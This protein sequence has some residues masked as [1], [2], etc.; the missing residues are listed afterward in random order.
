[1]PNLL[2][3]LL[4]EGFTSHE[5][6]EITF[7]E[8]ITVITGPEGAGKSSV[9][10]GIEWGLTGASRSTDAGGHGYESLIGPTGAMKVGLEFST[11]HGSHGPLQVLRSA[12]PKGTD[13]AVAGWKGGIKILEG[14]MLER[15]GTNGGVTKDQIHALMSSVRF[16]S[17]S[18]NDQK[19][20]L[21]DSLGLDFDLAGLIE[22][23]R[24]HPK[25][26]EFVLTLQ[27]F[28]GGLDD[29][30]GVRLLTALEKAAREERT[31]ANREVDTLTKQLEDK[32]KVDL[33]EGVTVKDKAMAESQLR[34]LRTERDKLLREQTQAS[35]QVAN[36]QRLEKEIATLGKRHDTTKAELTRLG[37]VK[38]A[39]KQDVSA[40][41]EVDSEVRDLTSQ[42]RGYEKQFADL[43]ARCEVNEGAL[44]RF[45]ESPGQCV[46]LPTLKCA[47]SKEG[48]AHLTGLRTTISTQQAE[49][50][51]LEAKI[52]EITGTIESLAERRAKLTK[53]VKA[54]GPTQ[55]EIDLLNA[56]LTTL[57]SEID[58]KSAALSAIIKSQSAASKGLAE[59][60]PALDERIEKGEALIALIVRAEATQE[61]QDEK[62][63][64]LAEA[65]ERAETL[66]ALVAELG[67][68]GV[69]SRLVQERLGGF[70]ETANR[71]AQTITG[72]EYELSLIHEPDLAVLVTRAGSD[73]R[74][75]VSLS[76]SEQIRMGAAIQVA[77]A[78]RIGFPL[79]VIDRV[80]TL[81]TDEAKGNFGA[82]MIEIAAKG[83]QV[84]AIGTGKVPDET[85]EG[86]QY[87][88]VGA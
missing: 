76:D 81:V 86:V 38:E 21:V 37:P 80:E 29:Q 20:L 3:R 78:E 16:F 60:I 52:E 28:A 88:E 73:G 1:M 6:T 72:G 69:V 70:V 35:A 31:G 32:A 26:S 4:L 27:D 23:M 84:I 82:A 40:V 43:N 54:E 49:L 42:R 10:H 68:K 41:G 15:L 56:N 18:T 74:L 9:G 46:V 22:L 33:P 39:P 14:K 34:G 62:T 53:P 63:Q 57:G 5:H 17:L 66:D 87:V 47:A 71:T 45:E 50:K 83:I 7:T 85:P 24:D 59:K 2:T 67:P 75:P 12:G 79:V 13:L 25:A 61:G 65:T 77:L 58:T 55:G 8:P 36:R 48:S 30:T 19:R 64:A 44:K 51:V 11:Q